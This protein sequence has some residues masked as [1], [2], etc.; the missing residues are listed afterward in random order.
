[1]ERASETH[2]TVGMVCNLYLAIMLSLY[3]QVT[4][5]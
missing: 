1:M 3:M 4:W 5:G 2:M